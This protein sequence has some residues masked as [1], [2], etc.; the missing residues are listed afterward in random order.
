LPLA[1]TQNVWGFSVE[2]V[3]NTIQLMFGASWPSSLEENI[4]M[5]KVYRYHTQDEGDD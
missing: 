2:N 1:V 3:L 5:W 4:K